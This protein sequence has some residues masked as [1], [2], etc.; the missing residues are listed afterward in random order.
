MLAGP[1]RAFR[2]EFEPG[3]NHPHLDT[4]APCRQWG[5]EVKALGTCGLH[6]PLPPELAERL[7]GIFRSPGRGIPERN[8]AQVALPLDPLPQLPLPDGLRAK[9]RQIPA[10][11]SRNLLP[12]WT[13]RTR[14]V[15]AASCLLAMALTFS[16]GHWLSPGQ[17]RYGLLSRSTRFL[18]AEAGSR[19]IEALVRT[20]RGIVEGCE[21][22][23]DSMGGLLRRVGATPTQAED[24]KS[25]KRV[26]AE[27]APSN[28]KENLHGNRPAH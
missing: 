7:G 3:G 8:D 12:S 21:I 17:E 4:C 28:R 15:T 14:D 18:L 9:L 20:G 26:A 24:P 16:A 13:V 5:D 22:A 1:C 10:S 27:T 25:R 19:G 11:T 6:V 23:N 2:E